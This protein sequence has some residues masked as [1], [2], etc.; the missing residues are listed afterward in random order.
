MN[1]AKKIEHYT[2]SFRKQLAVIQALECANSPKLGLQQKILYVAVLDALS[3][4]I[5]P[6]KG[7]RDRFISFI[8][9]FADWKESEKV[10]LPHLHRLFTLVPDPEYEAVR[11]YA[12]RELAKWVAGAV[13][14]LD[15]D[16]DV[17]EVRKYWPKPQE[18]RTPLPGIDLEKLQHGGLLY[19]YRNSLVH[20]Y[21]ALGYGIEFPDD[22]AP[23]Y[24]TMDDMDADGNIVQGGWELVYPTHYFLQITNTCLTN[25]EKY[26]NDN[27]LNPLSSYDLGSYWL[28]G[29]NEEDN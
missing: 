4:S 20:E 28:E 26:L 7:N 16:P 8:R 25:L 5:Y 23:Y 15:Q 13:V 27:G 6:N 11:K 21:R 22:T 10:S 14:H 29:L 12:N 24:M 9:R 1:T 18:H 2:G 3:K 17:H 19:T